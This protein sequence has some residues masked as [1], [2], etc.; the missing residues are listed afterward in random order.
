MNASFQDFG[1]PLLAGFKP[2]QAGSANR[3]DVIL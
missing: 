2:E 1:I 3:A